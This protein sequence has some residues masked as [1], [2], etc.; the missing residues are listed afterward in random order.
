MF[1][2]HEVDYRDLVLEARQTKRG[3]GVW[4]LEGIGYEGASCPYP[5]FARH[6]SSGAKERSLS[7]K[8]PIKIL[9]R[10]LTKGDIHQWW[11]IR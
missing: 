6:W 5:A 3:E 10:H 2:E 11:S 7:C 4:K 8:F 1:L 9:Y